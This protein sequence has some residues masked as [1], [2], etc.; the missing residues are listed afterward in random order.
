M[1]FDLYIKS[2]LINASE[3]F[4]MYSFIENYY[5][6]WEN[7]ISHFIYSIFYDKYLLLPPKSPKGT[8]LIQRASYIRYV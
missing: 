5:I 7:S 3:S 1:Y 6:D 2:L 8:Q 4:F